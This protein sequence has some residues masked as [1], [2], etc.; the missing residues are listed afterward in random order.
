MMGEAIPEWGPT[1]AERVLGSQSNRGCGAA[2]HCQGQSP[3]M[4]VG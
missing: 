4:H 1:V 3:Q 2:S